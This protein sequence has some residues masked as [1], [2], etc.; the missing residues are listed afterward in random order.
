LE[1]VSR[2]LGLSRAAWSA[3]WEGAAPVGGPV[4]GLLTGNIM[5]VGDAP[6][7]PIRSLSGGIAC[8]GDQRPDGR[9]GRCQPSPAGRG[10]RWSTIRR[11]GSDDGR[12][13]GQAVAPGANLKPVER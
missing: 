6:G 3:R 12:G 5:L 9:A 11:S 7:W 13:E 8:G 2:R 4:A 1:H 10:G